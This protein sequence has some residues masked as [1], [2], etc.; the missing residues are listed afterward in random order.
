MLTADEVIA[1]VRVH[2]DRVHDAVRRLGCGP[3]AATQVVEKSA[4]GLVDAVARQPETVGDPVG[5][6]FAKAR[7]LGRQAAGGDD[8]LPVGGG[9]LSSDANQLRLAEALESRP[10]RE[11]AALLLRDSYDLP[12]AAVGTS[13]G[14]DAQGAMEVVGAARLAFLPTLLASV[15]AVPTDH[16]VDLAALA[17]LAG[18][19]GPASSAPTCCTPRNEPAGC[20]QG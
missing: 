7:A 1:A 5:W 3:E 16:A 13:L 19:C 15:P 18:T 10:E 4:L 9:L 6:W 17:R 14:L 8:D 20:W 11:R 12:A 2:A